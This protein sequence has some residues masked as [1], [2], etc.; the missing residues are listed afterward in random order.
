MGLDQNGG[1][2]MRFPSTPCPRK[3]D[4]CFN[5]VH[6]KQQHRGLTSL[7]KTRGAQ[8]VHVRDLLTE[9]SHQGEEAGGELLTAVRFDR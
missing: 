2:T 3:V 9:V 8:V 1:Q 7:L 4:E 6:L 5:R